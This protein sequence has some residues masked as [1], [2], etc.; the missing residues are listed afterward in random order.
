M[1]QQLLSRV[2]GPRDEGGLP[3]AMLIAVAVLIVLAGV[4]GWVVVGMGQP[5]VTQPVQTDVAVKF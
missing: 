3:L 2:R 1:D 4:S 5:P